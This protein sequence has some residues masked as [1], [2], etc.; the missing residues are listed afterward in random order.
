MDRYP[1]LKT[2]R[3]AKGLTQAQLAELISAAGKAVTQGRVSQWEN[4]SLGYTPE[5]ATQIEAATGGAIC[6]SDL[7][8]GPAP[9]EGEAA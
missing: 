8:F 5:W 3:T 2:Y 7:I 4:G 1:D 6:R 9:R